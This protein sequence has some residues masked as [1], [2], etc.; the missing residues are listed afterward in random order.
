[1]C[2][3]LAD[4]QLV[5]VGRVERQGVGLMQPAN[6]LFEVRLIDSDRRLAAVAAILGSA[7]RLRA[8]SRVSSLVLVWRRSFMS[9]SDIY[10]GSGRHNGETPMKT[11][12]HNH[13]FLAL[14]RTT[15]EVSPDRAGE[16][17]VRRMTVM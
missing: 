1:V 15:M 17:A 7:K 9:P 13:Y 5:D 12:S 4:V 6:E 3:V 8:S 14:L 10:S 2:E 11:G 16:W